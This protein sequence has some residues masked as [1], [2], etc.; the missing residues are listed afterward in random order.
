MRTKPPRKDI[1]A[2]N[3]RNV[4]MVGA[5]DRDGH[6]SRRVWDNL[7]RF[8]FSGGVFPVNPNRTRVWGRP[9]FASFE[10]MPEPPDHL[11]IF[12]PAE[13]TLEVLHKGAMAG[14]R[15]ATIYAASSHGRDPP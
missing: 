15:S 6:W 7:Q 10:A 8:Q 3:P 1:G 14:A 11:A 2:L 9:C 13:M 5:S 4:A 12:T